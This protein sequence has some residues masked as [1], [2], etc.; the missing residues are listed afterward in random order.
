[1]T[2]FRKTVLRHRPAL[3]VIGS[4][5]AGKSSVVSALALL[6]PEATSVVAKKFYRRSLT[7]QFISGLMKRLRS[8]DRGV[9]DDRSAPLV[10]LRATAA[11][12]INMC[13]PGRQR[14]RTRASVTVENYLEHCHKWIDGGPELEGASPKLR[15]FLRSAQSSPGHPTLQSTSDSRLV[16]D[17][18]LKKLPRT[19]ILDRSI[20]GFLIT[21]RKSD[22]P[23]LARGATWIEALT[24]PVTSVLLTLPYAEL[25]RR[26]QEM[27]APGHATYQRMLFEQALRQQP[28]D[29][30][31]LANLP[32]VQA[33]AT[34]ICELLRDEGHPDESSTE[35]A[36]NRKAVA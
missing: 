33:A 24:P 26:K 14:S 7:Y 12:W 36:G 21:D 25:T 8:T 30:V 32:S 1:M 15:G 29:L 31:L 19:T 23:I 28:S 20:A 35:T 2:E 5:G 17:H 16:P 4:D 9:F 10:T 3:A 11:M 13:F 34:A 22:M 6:N 18:E 27:S